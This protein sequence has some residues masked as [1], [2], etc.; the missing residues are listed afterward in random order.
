MKEMNQEIYL[1]YSSV[2]ASSLGIDTVPM[3][4]CLSCSFYA[5]HCKEGSAFFVVVLKGK[6]ERN[7]PPI[8]HTVYVVFGLINEC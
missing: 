4:G 6:G 8:K 3:P 1:I 5:K 2:A 7:G